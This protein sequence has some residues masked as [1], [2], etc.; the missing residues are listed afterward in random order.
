VA[1]Y[2][3]RRAQLKGLG[4]EIADVYGQDELDDEFDPTGA[5]RHWR[6]LAAETAESV[7][8]ER[9]FTELLDRIAADPPPK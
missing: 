4:I 1:A 8:S 5:R 9:P 2:K 7:D 3:E 6:R